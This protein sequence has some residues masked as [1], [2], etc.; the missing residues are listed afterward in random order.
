MLMHAPPRFPR[1][2]AGLATCA[3]LLGAV[4]CDSPVATSAPVD[5]GLLALSEA[6]APAS[7][8]DRLLR[9]L[10]IQ[11][12]GGAGLNAF[13]LP[14]SNQLDRIPQDPQNPLTLPKVQLG[15]KLFHETALGVNNLRPEG[16]E[17]YACASCHA[18]IAGFNS[19]HPQGIAEGGSGFGVAGE[20][21]RFLPEYNSDPIAPDALD[22]RPPANVNTAYQ[23]V[24]LWNGQFGA[25]GPNAGTEARWT[26][27]TPLESNLLG[28]HGLE[29]Q[30]HAGLAVHRMATPENSRVATIPE[31]KLMFQTAF[32]GDPSPVNRLNVA[33]AIAAF[34]R[35]MLS[36]KAP[37]QLWL[38]GQLDALTDQEK[39]GA[40]LFFNKANCVSCHA[41]PALNSMSFH[42]LGMNDL[43]GTHRPDLIDMRPFGGSM[44][45]ASRQGRGGFTGVDED[46]FKFK[47]PQIYNV[48][49]NT[50]LGHG[51][52]FQNAREVI[53]YKNAALAQNPFVPAD[54]LSPLFVPLGL[55]AP[56]IDALVAFVEG[57]LYDPDLFRF[58]PET[59]PSGN[60]TPMNDPQAR[61]D[62]GCDDASLVV[63]D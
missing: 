19:G 15:K 23:E 41:G 17:T 27:G 1:S 45:E 22:R 18:A 9:G 50:F 4:G 25:V 59:L 10:I 55:T 61:M 62:L 48:A 5:D 47:T 44:P 12:S 51:A 58:V 2:L 29:T 8:L 63:E 43:D 36:N 35:T 52:S 26:P 34:E 20:G 60:C 24:V 30:A 33:L 53:E 21:R 39:R 42:A 31:Y 7:N 40:V 56:E 38:R 16:R 28:F 49:D 54:R 6:P 37:W 46:Y 3:L 32:P 13:I 11:Q 14:Q 57:A